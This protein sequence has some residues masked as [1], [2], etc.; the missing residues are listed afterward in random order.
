MSV[1]GKYLTAKI[2]AA[3][4]VGNYSWSVTERYDKIDAITAADGGNNRKDFGVGEADI[5]LKLL[6]DV[7]DG[8]VEPV[9]AGTEITNLKLYRKASDAQP[10]YLFP[11]ARIFESTQGAEI[12]GR[13][14]F[15]CSGENV[16]SYTR[17][18]PGAV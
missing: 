2:G 9:V 18:E 10:A 8:E 16:G 7:A 11:T 4:I 15:T 14:E 13:V 3:E 12:R 6:I 1:S 5:S 17:N